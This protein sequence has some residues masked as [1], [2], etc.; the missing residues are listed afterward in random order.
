MN[1]GLLELAASALGD[2]L[3]EVVF[4]GG[5]TIELWI[6]DAAAPPVRPTTD[7]DVV[8][9]VATRSAF[10][11]FE[12][13]SEL[14]T[15]GF[16]EDRIRALSVPYLLAT[17]LEAFGSRGRRDFHGSRD[18]EDVVR[19]LDGRAELI[20]EVCAARDELRTYLAAFGNRAPEPVPEGKRELFARQAR[21]APD[22]AGEGV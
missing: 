8:L 22:A 15:R 1:I 18:F 7:V 5:A 13:R 4:V 19:L 2:L 17:K 20:G 9:G 3:D 14:R 11:E 16:S 21:F 10:Y 6:T 12:A